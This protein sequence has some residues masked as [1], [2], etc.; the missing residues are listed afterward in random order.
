MATYYGWSGGYCFGPRH[1]VPLLPLLGLGLI[2]RLEN[3]LPGIWPRIDIA[4]LG[5]TSIVINLLGAL[6]YWKFW[7]GHPLF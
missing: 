3:P 5:V 2:P 7:G 6:P 4:I 1:V